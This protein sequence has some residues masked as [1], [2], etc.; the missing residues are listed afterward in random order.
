[1]HNVVTDMMD[2]DVQQPLYSMQT[3]QIADEVASRQLDR[4]K[5][6]ETQKEA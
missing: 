2:G 1:M 3:E 6:D 5:Q 4:S